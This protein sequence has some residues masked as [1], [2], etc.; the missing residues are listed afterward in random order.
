[1]KRFAPSGPSCCLEIEEEP[2]DEEFVVCEGSLERIPV[3]KSRERTSRTEWIRECLTRIDRKGK[4]LRVKQSVIV[5][6]GKVRQVVS[7]DYSTEERVKEVITG[8]TVVE[9][10]VVDSVSR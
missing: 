5:L 3:G 7:T 1:M 4:Q 10:M 9:G 6:T 2:E 8:V